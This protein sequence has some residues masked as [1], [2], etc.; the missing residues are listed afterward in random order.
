MI[1]G[2]PDNKMVEVT[3]ETQD[4][5]ERAYH[6]YNQSETVICQN[7]DCRKPFITVI[8]KRNGKVTDKQAGRKRKYCYECS[9]PKNCL[10]RHDLGKWTVEE[11]Y[12]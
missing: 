6:R 8:R 12:L 2:A 10:T 11:T 1:A 5:K 7:P 4:A 9:P 3:Q